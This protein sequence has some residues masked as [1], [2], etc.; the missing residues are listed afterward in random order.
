MMAGFNR[1]FGVGLTRAAEA[2]DVPIQLVYRRINTYNYSTVIPRVPPEEM[3]AY[4]KRSEEKLG[5][6]VGRL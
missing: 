2:Y 5:A 6:A 4:G 3:E 1:S